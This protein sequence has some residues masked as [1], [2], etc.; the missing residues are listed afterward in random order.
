M[1]AWDVVD[2]PEGVNV[3]DSTCAFKLK[4]FPDG[5]IKK[6]KACFCVQGDQ[7]VHG[8]DFFETYAPVVQ[9]T[10]I[11]LMLILEVLLGLKS[12]QGNITAAFVQADVEKGDNIYVEMHQGFKEQGI[13]LKLKKTLY[14]LRQ[15]PRAFWLYLTEKMNLCGMEQAT[16]DPCLFIGAEVM[17][18]C[19]VDDLI[20]WTMSP[21]LM[22][23]R[24]N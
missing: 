19:Y 18:I 14:G 1:G 7:Q 10:A 21:T 6:C 5:L 4:Q 11:Q 23:W 13:V 15:S 2:H 20:F 17:C 8:V 22:S 3:I 16:F 12:K 9:W 24:I